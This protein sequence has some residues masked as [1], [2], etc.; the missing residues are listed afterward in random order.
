MEEVKKTC[1]GNPRALPSQTSA[2]QA[3]ETPVRRG[4]KAGGGEGVRLSRGQRREPSA[5]EVARARY[6][7]GA[8][9]EVVGLQC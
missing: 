7:P 6:W 9:W 1:R 4:R 2:P 5:V 3:A 8:G